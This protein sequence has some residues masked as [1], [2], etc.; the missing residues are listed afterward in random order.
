VPVRPGAL[1]SPA[2]VN[3]P[4]RV[5]IP[6]IGVDAAVYPVGITGDTGLF[7]VPR[8]VDRVGWYRHGPGLE[9]RAGSVVIAGHVDGR[10]QGRGAFYRLREL[11]P[12]DRLSVTGADGRR[13]AYRV[14]ARED[15]DKTALPVRRLF[16]RDGAHRLTLITCGGPFD[17]ATRTYRDNLVVTAVPA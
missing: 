11:A 8:A 7:E 5:R 4:R 14:V 9:A 2:A 10:T 1:P 12:G 13:R 15:F 6:A 17:R 3:P 16:A